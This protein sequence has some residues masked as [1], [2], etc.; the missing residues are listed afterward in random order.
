MK[1]N[2]FFIFCILLIGCAKQ[3]AFD[4]SMAIYHFEADVIYQVFKV[5][6]T[7]CDEYVYKNPKDI[8]DNPYQIG[9]E[10]LGRRQNNSSSIKT[11]FSI[12]SADIYIN[13]VFIAESSWNVRASAQIT[14]PHSYSFGIGRPYILQIMHDHGIPGYPKTFKMC[15]V[16]KGGQPDSTYLLHITKYNAK[17]IPLIPTDIS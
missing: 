12:I 3:P 14:S 16:N 13:D 5:N 11:D 9:F 7:I 15:V 2:T 4:P 17:L 6:Q 8:E 10:L 1:K